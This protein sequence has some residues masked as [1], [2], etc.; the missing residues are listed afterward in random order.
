M[1]V[2]GGVG[3]AAPRGGNLDGVETILTGDW[4]AGAKAGSWLASIAGSLVQGRG[5]GCLD[6][7]VGILVSRHIGWLL[8][9]G[10]KGYLYDDGME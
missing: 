7:K 5:S 2:G 10:N 4:Q 1:H 6:S 8:G 3:N 9:C